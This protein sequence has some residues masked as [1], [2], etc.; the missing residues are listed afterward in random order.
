[1]KQGSADDP[2]ASEPS[3]ESP[4]TSSTETA[5]NSEPT[6]VTEEPTETT[7]QAEAETTTTTTDDRPTT[8]QPL[9]WIYHRE[10]ARDGREKTKQLHLQQSTAQQESAFRSEVEEN[11]GE[12]VELTDLRE[13]AILVAMNHPSEVADQLRE[14]GYDYQ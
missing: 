4:T 10:N 1:M 13:A 6:T 3:E 2:F 7:G 12:S 8:N 14:W 11:V 9:P 5:S